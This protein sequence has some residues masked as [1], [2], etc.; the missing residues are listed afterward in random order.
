MDGRVLARASVTLASPLVAS[1]T[2]VGAK[3]K[4][5][6]SVEVVSLAATLLMPFVQSPVVPQQRGSRASRG[7]TSLCPSRL[8][9]G[10]GDWPRYRNPCPLFFSP[11]V[12][13]FFPAC[14]PP[15]PALHHPL[16]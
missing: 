10:K 9:P 15:H 3:V 1:P 7:P 8:E 12:R 11:Q 13:G 14:L 2:K 4:G 5:T 16:S 6:R